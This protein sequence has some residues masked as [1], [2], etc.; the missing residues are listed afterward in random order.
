MKKRT[1]L[2][3][4]S[5]APIGLVSA[6]SDPPIEKVVFNPYIHTKEARVTIFAVDKN[7]E[8]IG[9]MIS[10]LPKYIYSGR[11]DVLTAAFKQLLREFKDQKIDLNDIVEISFEKGSSSD[12]CYDK[13]KK[14]KERKTTLRNKFNALN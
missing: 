11:T 12:D 13:F 3:L 7:G 8:L 5:F 6:N 2:G 4:L 14:E 1:L 9:N 10:F